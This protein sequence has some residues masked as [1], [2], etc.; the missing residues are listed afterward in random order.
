MI[1]GHLKSIEAMIENGHPVNAVHSLLGYS[2]L[3]GAADFNNFKVLKK[4]I[5]SGANVNQR[6]VRA[7]R[8]PLHYAAE[9]GRLEICTYL[10]DRGAHKDIMDSA[11]MRPSHLAA[12]CANL[13]I[14]YVG[15]SRCQVSG[16][17]V[18]DMVAEI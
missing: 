6:D 17:K 14:R 4:L 11:S 9:S 8:T 12:G 10:I 16:F 13:A 1:K 7:G 5:A 3:H 15:R 2:A 18:H